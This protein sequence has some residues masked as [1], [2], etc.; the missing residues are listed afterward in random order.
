MHSSSL[1]V[2]L[3]LS[4]NRKHVSPIGRRRPIKPN[5]PAHHLSGLRLTEGE[6]LILLAPLCSDSPSFPS[7]AP[8]LERVGRDAERSFPSTLCLEDFDPFNV[9]NLLSAHRKLRRYRDTG[10]G[11]RRSRPRMARF[12]R[13]ERRAGRWGGAREGATQL[14]RTASTLF[15]IARDRND[16]DDDNDNGNDDDRLQEDHRDDGAREH[17]H[18][19]RRVRRGSAS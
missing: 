4:A 19:K 11:A 13:P 5:T 6:S 10:G 17:A 18:R 15:A 14:R 3:R 2:V 8:V 7:P 16:N 12:E 1:G 9:Q